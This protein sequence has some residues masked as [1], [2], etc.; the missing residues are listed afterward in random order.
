MNN[1]G[2]EMQMI[3]YP[4]KE[5][6]QGHYFKS[7]RIRESWDKG[8]ERKRSKFGLQ[9]GTYIACNIHYTYMWLLIVAS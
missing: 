1:M 5:T 9:I 8:A 3:L 6:C 2:Y 4:G 7:I